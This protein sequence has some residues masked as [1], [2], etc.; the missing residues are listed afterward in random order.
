VRRGLSIEYLAVHGEERGSFAGIR[1][2]RMPRS[3]T[4]PV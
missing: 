2:N 4:A 1:F 3:S